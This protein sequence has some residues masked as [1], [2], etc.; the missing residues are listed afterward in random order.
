MYLDCREGYGFHC[1]NG[2]KCLRYSAVCS[3]RATCKDGSD[4]RDCCKFMLWAIQ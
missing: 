2:T 1:D 3:G 4:E